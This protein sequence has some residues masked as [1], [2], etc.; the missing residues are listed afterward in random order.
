MACI[1]PWHER[2]NSFPTIALVLF[3]LVDRNLI[4][5]L[6]TAFT[7]KYVWMYIGLFIFY[8]IGISY[9]QL[10][11]E[12]FATLE[13]KLTLLIFPII[14]AGESLDTSLK[15]RSIF[16]WFS[17]SVACAAVYCILKN[18]YVATL[19]GVL[20]TKNLFL[21]ELL[22]SP[23]MHPGYFSNYVF[24]AIVSLSL[25]IVY[26]DWDWF[27]SKKIQGS[28]LLFLLIFLVMLTSK[29]VYIAFAFFFVWILF[30][31][32]KQ[33]ATAALKLKFFAGAFLAL[34]LFV[35]MLVKVFPERFTINSQFKK[36][37]PKDVSIG[38]SI[39]S[40][41]AAYIVGASLV[42]AN[43]LT[44]Y[45]TGMSNALLKEELRARGYVQLVA[46]NMHTHNQLIKT[47]L[48]IGLFGTLLMLLII[49]T[50]MWNSNKKHQYLLLWL[51][52]LCFVNC[53]TDDMWDIQAGI[54]F[55]M[56]FGSLLFFQSAVFTVTNLQNQ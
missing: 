7:N 1:I 41:K 49:C 10:P 4:T 43:W 3:F 45:G 29:T 22:A 52:V 17:L 51:G 15:W 35:L 26:K 42:K 9:S 13:R 2:W 55:F 19:P 36:L 6:I 11:K 25:P 44:G 18:C 20:V 30:M 32:W 38:T 34:C 46:K 56:F 23:I 8:A 5:K 12:A 24:L 53:C 54:V 50:W 28:L 33:L 21:Y 27:F 47:S 31:A 39:V 48:E 40:R 37:D 14:F 16:K